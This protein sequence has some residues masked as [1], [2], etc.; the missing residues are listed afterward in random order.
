[1]YG[2]RVQNESKTL[3]K[4]QWVFLPERMALYVQHYLQSLFAKTND[5]VVVI[6]MRKQTEEQIAMMGNDNGKRNQ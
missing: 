1:M 3:K 6:R 4:L 2:C 5:I